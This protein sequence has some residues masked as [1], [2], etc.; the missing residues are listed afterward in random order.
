M[1]R[2]YSVPYTGNGKSI[3]ILVVQLNVLD[4]HTRYYTDT[5]SVKD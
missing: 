4:L 3:F 1:H 5:V 2:S